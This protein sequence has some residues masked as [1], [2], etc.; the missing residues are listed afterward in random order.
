MNIKKQLD[1][2]L[3]EKGY[4]ISR[5]ESHSSILSGKVY[6][7]GQIM[8]K[9]GKY[10]AEKGIK[11]IEIIE[12]PEYVSRG[13]YKLEK[14]LDEFLINVKNKI[15]MDVGCSTGGFT[16]CLLQNEAEK[17]YAIDV[18]YGQFDFKLRNNDHVVLLERTNIRYLDKDLI[19]NKIDVI[20]IDVSFISVRKFLHDLIPLCNDNFGIIILIKP[21]FESERKGVI[22]GVIRTKDIH[23]EIVNSQFDYFT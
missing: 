17:V 18:G 4:F 19:K 21:Q 14:A 20:T 22:K 3:Y 10:F 2:I 8:D 23:L 7:N 5:A 15:C 1:Q 9:P 13:G 6:I 11:K 16:D 12:E